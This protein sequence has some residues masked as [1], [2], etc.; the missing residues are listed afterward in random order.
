MIK[1]AFYS[2]ICISICYTI[3]VSNFPNK[4]VGTHQWQENQIRAHRFLYDK[5]SDT[6][7]V[8]TSL[9]ARIILDSISY[10]SSCAFSA[11]VVE[12][13]LR[14]ILSKETL[15]RYVLIETNYLL[16]PSNGEL[17]RVNTKGPTP[18][19]RRYIPMMREQN[20]P[21]SLMGHLCMQGALSP[22]GQVDLKRLEKNIEDRIS[23]DYTHLLSEM[24]VEE[25]IQTIMPLVHQLESLGVKIVLYEMPLNK[26]LSHLPSNEQTRQIVHHLFPSEKY[27]YIPCDTSNYLTNDGEHLD[28]EGRRRYSHYIK[29]MLSSITIL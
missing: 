18:F 17:V 3:L 28:E 1:K 20:S 14:L 12:D 16:R 5:T 13:G 9:S 19:L 24:Q 4:G 22:V 10:V 7:I 26:R 23:E 6:V 21:S 15:P 11:C 2:F 27:T 8:G 29:I 25:R